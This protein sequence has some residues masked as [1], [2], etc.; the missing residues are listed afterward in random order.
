MIRIVDKIED[1]KY[2]THSG[3]MHADEVF[4]TAFLSLYKGDIDLFRTPEVNPDNYP[5]VIIYDVGR[6]K[7]DHH[8]EGREVRE[9]GIPYCSLGLLWKEF[10]KDFLKKRNIEHVDEVFEYLDKDFIEGIDAIDNGIFQKV[11]STYKMRNLCDVIKLFNPSF[12]SD[13]KESTQFL[14]AVDVAIKIFEE[15][16]LSIVGRVKAKKILEA[17][18]PEAIEKHYL[19]L[20][21]FMPYEESIYTLDTNK[22]IYF[23]VFPSNRGGYSAKTIFNSS[24]DRVYRVEFPEEW[25]GHGK[26]LAEI[27]GVE[28]ATFCHLAKFIVSATTREAIIKLV[29]MAISK[30][31]K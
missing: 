20:D 10:G 15:E 6:G 19:E 21:K 14:K 30:S 12:E 4:A 5:D 16:V 22:Q 28:G 3:T 1:A 29:E 26:E 25:A 11:E 7:F 23:V 9:N 2:I 8:Q 27:T 18:I 24:E 13:E 17:K 31:D